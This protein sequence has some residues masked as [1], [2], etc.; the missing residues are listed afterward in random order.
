MG[1]ILVIAPLPPPITGQSVACEALIHDL[2]ARG[3][4]VDV[5]NLAK[6]SFLMR[7]NL[8]KRIID[9]IKLSIK[10]LRA[11]SKSD[12]VYLT[13][14]QS[15]L[16]N[17]KDLLVLLL[18]G[19]NLREVTFLH[20]HG[21]V[22]MRR[23][24]SRENVF[25]KMLNQKII[26]DVAGAI[27]LGDTFSDIYDGI[28]DRAKISVVKN[29]APVEAFASVAC[30]Q[31]KT[32]RVIEKENPIRVL[33]LSNLLRGKGYL[34]IIDAIQLLPEYIVEKFH[35]DFAGEFES[36]E[37]GAE[38]LRHLERLRSVCY[39][40][41]VRGEKKSKLLAQ[42]NILVLPTYY[43]YEG[44]PICILEAYASGCAVITTNHG[45]IFDIF[46]PGLNGWEVTPRSA[47]SVADTLIDILR[48]RE[49]IA[50]IGWNNFEFAHKEYKC[51]N[52]LLKIRLAL[53][54]E[55]P[56]EINE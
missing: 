30:V 28:I 45:G 19:K 26:C 3:Y 10:V 22:G 52:H 46:T 48:R 38:F 15:V 51:S 50:K 13:P 25:L 7:G 6:S 33:F 56:G 5:I 41:I 12:L 39:H 35:F 44:Q 9:I 34:E 55:A 20:L 54:I 8:T 4:A 49:E 31:E 18:L 40:G 23:L 32:A 17:I 11:K 43:A 2:I 53:G 47:E 16:G 29:F 36:I 27:V 1:T 14:S 24:L 21:G 42:S 37:A